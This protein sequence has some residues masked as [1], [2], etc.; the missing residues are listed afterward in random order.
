[1]IAIGAD[2]AFDELYAMALDTPYTRIIVYG[3]SIDDIVGCINV[4]DIFRAKLTNQ[5]VELS[6]LVKQVPIVPENLTMGKLITLLKVRHSQLAVVMDEHGTTL[7]VVT[8]G[9][10]MAELMDDV[11]IDEFKQPEVF[12]VIDHDRILMPGSF[13]LHRA[14]KVLGALPEND[15]DTVNGLVLEVLGRVPV[16][17]DEVEL[18]ETILIVK[19]VEHHAATKLLLL[20]KTDSDR[21][22]DDEVEQAESDEEKDLW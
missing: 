18:E 3:D 9:D 12:T 19:E 13:K 11:E 1:M 2:A 5:E 10:L 21:V 22:T 8:V 4:R 16:V 14:E 6:S 15:A 7:G 20:R 17:G